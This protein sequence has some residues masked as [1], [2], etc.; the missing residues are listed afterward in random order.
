MTDKT[1]R[2]KT[3]SNEPESFEDAIERLESLVTGLEAGEVPL[4][5]SVKAFEE[6]QQLIAYCEQKLKAAEQALRQIAREADEA[7][8]DDSIPH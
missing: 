1:K 3:E 8:G 7:T 6:G 4:E 2:T 5:K